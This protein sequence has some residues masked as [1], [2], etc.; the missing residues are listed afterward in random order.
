M[1]PQILKS[2][3]CEVHLDSAM[4]EYLGHMTH[5]SVDREKVILPQLLMWH[6]DLFLTSTDT[7]KVLL[8]AYPPEFVNICV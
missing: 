8:H 7:V 5:V 3:T 2:E 6:Q 4:T 1:S